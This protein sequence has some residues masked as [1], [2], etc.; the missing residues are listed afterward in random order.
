MRRDMCVS[1]V[2]CFTEHCVAPMT[3]VIYHEIIFWSDCPTSHP[4]IKVIWHHSSMSKE[5]LKAAPL[6]ETSLS[7][8]IWT[9]SHTFLQTPHG[10][11]GYLKCSFPALVFTLNPPSS[12]LCVA[13]V[14]PLQ[15]QHAQSSPLTASDQ[16]GISMP[17]P[18]YPK[19]LTAHLLWVESHWTLLPRALVVTQH[20]SKD[21]C[22]S[23]SN[24]HSFQTR[25]TIQHKQRLS[26]FLFYNF[27]CIYNAPPLEKLM[28]GKCIIEAER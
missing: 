16:L 9:Q 22:H 12:L 17:R 2:V 14:L 3:Q 6:Y 18:I 4:Q 21:L 13:F 8:R 19:C 28:S 25:E 11:C 23:Q 5:A 27:P 15:I 1:L 20:F 7:Q 24:I 26:F 10:A